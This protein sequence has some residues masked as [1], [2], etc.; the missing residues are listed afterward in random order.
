A[1]IEANMHPDLKAKYKD[2]VIIT[3]KYLDWISEVTELDNALQEEKARTQRQIDTSVAARA[4]HKNLLDRLSEPMHTTHHSVSAP[5]TTNVTV[6]LQKL[7]PPKKQILEDHEGCTRCC[8][9]YCDHARNLDAC[10]MKK[11]NTWLDPRTT[12]ALTVE[13]AMAA[14]A[15][16]SR[17]IADFAYTEEEVCD[18][19][20]SESN[21][22]VVN[23]R[24]NPSSLGDTLRLSWR[25]WGLLSLIFPLPYTLS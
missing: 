13:M 16:K 17:T 20:T 9:L 25:L 23:P 8:V 15:A 5:A 18:V 11:N 21:L 1:Q 10:P 12:K 19:D 3:T 7:T 4:K 14:K 24:L 22:Y 6:C 2:T